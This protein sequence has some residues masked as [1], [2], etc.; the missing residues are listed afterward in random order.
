MS[1]A[2]R[3]FRECC[4]QGMQHGRYLLSAAPGLRMELVLWS[5][6]VELAGDGG[7][8]MSGFEVFSDELDSGGLGGSKSLQITNSK[9]IFNVTIQ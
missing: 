9:T 3:S 4:E 1:E 8:G 2:A 6:H 5:L 7:G